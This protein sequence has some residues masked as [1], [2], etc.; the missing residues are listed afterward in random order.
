MIIYNTLDEMRA[1][2]RGRVGLFDLKETKGKNY[3]KLYDVVTNRQRQICKIGN[4]Y[5][6]VQLLPEKHY[7]IPDDE[8]LNEIL[9]KF[10]EKRAYSTKFI[11]ELKEA[12]IPYKETRCKTC[13]GRV[14]KIEYCTVE[15]VHGTDKTKRKENDP[16]KD[17]EK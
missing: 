17:S 10:K 9:A 4:T 15:V 13:S 12:G 3:I 11:E 8:I 16:K 7:S 6:H 1:V 2:E 14:V 5:Q